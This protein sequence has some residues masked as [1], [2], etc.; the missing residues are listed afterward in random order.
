MKKDQETPAHKAERLRKLA[1]AGMIGPDNVYDLANNC[2]GC[3]L[4]PNE[5]LVNV[6]GHKA[7]S[8]FELVAWS[9]GEIRHNNWYTG[10]KENRQATLEEKRKMYVIGTAET[11]STSPTKS[12][13]IQ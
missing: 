3:H 10:G 1:A 4:V 7:G 9:Q 2:Y 11:P 12:P 8:D 5:K 6:G 13:R